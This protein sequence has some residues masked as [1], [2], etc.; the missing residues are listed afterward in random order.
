MEETKPGKIV[1]LIQ[2]NSVTCARYN[3]TAVQENVITTIIDKIQRYLTQN[4]PI[5]TD[6]F[7]H[8]EVTIKASDIAHGNSKHYVLQ[9]LKELRKKDIEFA[10]VNNH[11][12]VEEVCTGIINTIRNIKETDYIT[13][14]ISTW[15][16][17]Y[18][19]YWGKGVGGT[20]YQKAI[21]MK[22]RSVYAKRLYKICNRWKD[23]GGFDMTLDEFREMFRLENKYRLPANLK[24]RVLEPA[25]KELKEKADLYFEYELL[26][27]KSRSYNYI[28]FKVISSK[29]NNVNDN[30][31]F[32]YQFVYNFLTQTY[33][34][35]KSDKAF[36]ITEKLAS[37]V[38]MLRRVYNTF[39][40]IKEDVVKN[41]KTDEDLIRLT[42]YV[43]KNDYGIE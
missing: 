22:L 31:G 21:A 14:E 20:A 18:L 32:W 1:S 37:D 36:V 27:V 35:Y 7:G 11:G 42:R 39:L 6:L 4:E 3:Y 25:K 24:Q 30:K 16:I 19:V 2:P 8:P 23:K 34:T 17:P 40:R 29:S 26:K 9:Q 5:Q 28:S 12:E 43:L 41:N 15:A 38:N 13:V 10:Y 33:P